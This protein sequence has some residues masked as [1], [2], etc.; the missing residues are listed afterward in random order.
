MS[1]T[2]VMPYG[3]GQPPTC[4]V[5]MPSR[6]TRSTRRPATAAAAPVARMPVTRCSLRYSRRKIMTAPARS[7]MT[8][9]STTRLLF[10]LVSFQLLHVFEPDP[11]IRPVSEHQHESGERERNDNGG[12]DKGL[13]NRIGILRR[14][15]V[16]KRR[17]SLLQAAD[18]HQCEMGGVGEQG[19]AQ[20]DP[21]ELFAEQ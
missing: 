9:G 20:D 3:A 12:Q 1:A 4:S 5:W 21:Q 8:I 19:R 18:R 15:F 2:S 16:Q 7:G 11:D 6:A 17:S 10:I 13:R 14:R